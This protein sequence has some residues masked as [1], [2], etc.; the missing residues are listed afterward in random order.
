V[1]A[2]Q[3]RR[4]GRHINRGESAALAE[5]LL[6]MPETERRALMPTFTA[7]VRGLTW[8]NDRKVGPLFVAG[9]ACLPTAATLAAW[10]NR[11]ALRWRIG[12][13]DVVITT[14]LRRDVPWLADLATRVA[15]NL[16]ARSDFGEWRFA[17]E[18]VKVSGA[19]VPTSDAFV[20]GWVT[21]C[22]RSID[23]WPRDQLRADPFL[24]V[25][26]PRLFEVDGVGS[27]LSIASWQREQRG[28][29]PAA[30]GTAA[31]V[32]LAA[33]GRVSRTFLID[34]TVG[35]L[36]RG[37][38]PS[39][40]SAFVQLHGDL[41]PTPDEIGQRQLDY[42]RLLLAEPNSVATLAQRALRDL[43]AAGLLELDS[44]LDVSRH[45]LDRPDKTLV[46]TQL[47][48]LDAVARRDKARAGDVADAMGAALANPHL[49]LADRAA[50]LIAKH[51]GGRTAAVVVVPDAPVAMPPVRLVEQL[52]PPITTVPELVSEIVGVLGS[53]AEDAVAWERVLDGLARLAT[54]Q[55]DALRSAVDAI[56]DAPEEPA[57][58]RDRYADWSPP[59]Q[60][61]R[62]LDAITSGTLKRRRIWDFVRGTARDASPA[63]LRPQLARGAGPLRVFA[64]RLQELA[65]TIGKPGTH[66]LLATPTSAT[67]HV[68]LATLVDRI[69]ELERINAEPGPV[70]LGQALVRLPRDID[71][72]AAA[73]AKRLTSAAGR[74]LAAWLDE[75]G[76]KDPAMY[77]RARSRHRV[78]IDPAPDSAHPVVRALLGADPWWVRSSLDLCRGL[79]PTVMPSHREVIAAYL[80]P[81]VTDAA[82]SDVR[83]GAAVLSRLGETT[84]PIGPAVRL[85]LAYGLGAKHA[86]DRAATVDMVLQLAASGDLV[87]REAG[88]HVGTLCVDGELVLG[89]VVV[90]LDEVA[91]AGAPA[92]AWA[93]LAGALPALLGATKPPRGLPDLLQLASRV[94]PAGSAVGV[95]VR[96]KLATLSDRGASRLSTEA[97]RLL[98]RLG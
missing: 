72:D 47:S 79:W 93:I 12:K 45:V 43:D 86:E 59:V 60:L 8:Q 54:T 56:A 15:A 53:A 82:V 88:V 96:H 25:L 32:A 5:L 28:F 16:P 48:W 51:S 62:V 22:F 98:G 81:A 41:R 80:L 40:L 26:L 55:S 24:D 13:F 68:D 2:E 21:D 14:L 49:D 36:L 75:G 78:G 42:L 35:R 90:A 91:R 17:A 7:E 11:S 58:L 64:A 19:P 87:D 65:L 74:T 34:A 10:F 94:A 27:A 69:A 89:R 29:D 83:G 18:L 92:A 95:D 66:R 9:A 77:V 38:R 33:E 61:R 70:D 67:G 84:G 85:C 4:I 31:L 44:L 57:Y 50:A 37:D 30:A 39:A 46:R 63:D 20:R 52:P 23:P 97:R 6:E 1:N 3:S 76:L 71:P 73:E